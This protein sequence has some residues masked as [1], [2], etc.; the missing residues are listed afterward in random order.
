MRL[1]RDLSF[2]TLLLHRSMEQ[3]DPPS[4]VNPP[5]SPSPFP[6]GKEDHTPRCSVKELVARIQQRQRQSAGDDADRDREDGAVTAMAICH[7][8][9]TDCSESSDNDDDN[10]NRAVAAFRYQHH[11]HHR[12]R[13]HNYH[14]LQQQQG[15]RSS[16]GHPLSPQTLQDTMSTDAPPRS[17]CGVYSPAT[18]QTEVVPVNAT[19]HYH[20]SSTSSNNNII[21]N[22]N[23]NNDEI[24]HTDLTAKIAKLR[25]LEGGL[26]GTVT[27]KEGTQ[28]C[29]TRVVA[30]MYVDQHAQD[31]A[32]NNDS[33]YSTK[34]YGSSKG[35]SPSFS[36]EQV[37]PEC[38][39]SSSLV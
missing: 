13:Q 21:N 31:V 29:V 33:G 16:R 39:R 32:D 5:P 9:R 22:N 2:E 17:R 34:V 1:S 36:G 10:E 35:N 7:D 23:N 37:E 19:H 11:Q 14:H 18:V 3:L 4:Q 12:Q 8:I 27:V 6:V 28:G 38:I 26:G 20:Y 15:R 24:R 30:K 25:M